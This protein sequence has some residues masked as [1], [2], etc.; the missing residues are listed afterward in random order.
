MDIDFRNKNVGDIFNSEE[1]LVRKYGSEQA[2][3]IKR[4]MAVLKAASCLAEVS[5]RPP[6]RRHELTENRKGQFAVDLKHPYRLVFEPNHNPLPRKEDGGL[7]LR[8]ITA[9]TI[10]EMEDYH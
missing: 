6:T 3:I 7:D 10:I 1:N 4:R 8:S 5:Y 9:I 2:R